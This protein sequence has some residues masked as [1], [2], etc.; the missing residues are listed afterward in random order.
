M[1]PD[2]FLRWHAVQM[3]FNRLHTAKIDVKIQS[4]RDGASP[5]RRIFP[6]QFTQLTVITLRKLRQQLIQTTELLRIVQ[7]IMQ[8]TAIWLWYIFSIMYHRH[9]S[10]TQHRAHT[11]LTSIRCPNVIRLP[12]VNNMK[13]PFRLSPSRR[14][15][16]VVQL[17]QLLLCNVVYDRGFIFILSDHLSASLCCQVKFVQDLCS[18]LYHCKWTK[19]TVAIANK[20]L[21]QSWKGD[22]EGRILL[23]RTGLGVC[24]DCI[25]HSGE[26]GLGRKS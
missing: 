2:W 9:R 24:W 26:P 14:W 21:R 8:Q 13:E 18:L 23:D 5:N 3:L 20:I 25:L 19:Q 12:E 10:N 17:R 16:Y 7:A 1:N 11:R 4:V 22:C 6:S 15:D